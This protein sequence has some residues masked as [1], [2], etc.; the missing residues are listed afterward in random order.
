MAQSKSP[1]TGRVFLVGAGPGDPGLVTL[2]GIECL[3]RADLVLYDYLVNPRIL[4]RLNPDAEAVCLGRHGD[5]RLMS[6]DKLNQ[7]LVAGTQAGKTVVRVKSGDSTIFARVA[8]EIDCRAAA[9]IPFEVVPGIT[10]ALAAGSYAGVPL[11][12]RDLASAIALVTGHEQ[13]GKPASAL[14]YAALA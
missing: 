5:R 7:R 4:S 9:G 8:E 3:R 1:R 10:A 13:D 2:R 6:Q 14:D 12:H 11:T